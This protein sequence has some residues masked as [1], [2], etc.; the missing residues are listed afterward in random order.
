MKTYTNVKDLGNLHEAVKEALEVKKNRFAYKQLGENK[1]LLMVFFNSSLRTRLSTQKA[2]LNLGMNNYESAGQLVHHA[3]FH[4]I[5][6]HAGDGLSLWTQHAY[7]N[8]EEMQK[9]AQAVRSAIG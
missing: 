6:R 1:T 2:G 4:L 9:L 3:H 5:P 8:V 7:E